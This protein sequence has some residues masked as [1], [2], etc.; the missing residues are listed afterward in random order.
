MNTEKPEAF[1]HI[2]KDGSVRISGGLIFCRP[3][4]ILN[5]SLIFTTHI[6]ENNYFYMELPRWWQLF[7]WIKLIR[8]LHS[9]TDPDYT[10]GNHDPH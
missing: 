3:T 10:E 6:I 5:D 4:A 8:L 1:I 2:R 7:Q 9:Y